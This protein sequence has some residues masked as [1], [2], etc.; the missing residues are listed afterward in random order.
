MKKH[1]NS[2]EIHVGLIHS[3][4]SGTRVLESAMNSFNFDVKS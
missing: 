2:K 3:D 4:Y 1:M